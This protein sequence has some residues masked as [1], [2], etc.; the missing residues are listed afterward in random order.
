[1]RA[2]TTKEAQLRK[3][4]TSTIVRLSDDKKEEKDASN[5]KSK[6][7][8]P[9]VAKATKESPDKET[10][11]LQGRKI[12]KGT[13]Q[14]ETSHPQG[15]KMSSFLVF[16]NKLPFGVFEEDLKDTS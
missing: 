12:S 10:V 4:S 9:S 6:S 7:Q 13:V 3:A 5:P 8:K 2:T 11:N 1:M 15:W 14:K 16:N